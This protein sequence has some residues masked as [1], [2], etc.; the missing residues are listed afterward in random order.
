VLE[1]PTGPV[2]DRASEDVGIYWVVP[3]RSNRPVVF[4][5]GVESCES[6]PRVGTF[7]PL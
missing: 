5:Y 1:A 6:Q 7:V 3:L 2:E 4:K